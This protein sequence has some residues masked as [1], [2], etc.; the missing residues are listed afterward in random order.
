MIAYWLIPAEPARSWFTSIIKELACKYNGPIFEPH[1]T[2]YSCEDSETHTREVVSCLGER[3]AAV[4]LEPDRIGYTDGFTKTLF[5][6]FA[7]SIAADELSDAIRSESQPQQHYELQPHLSL[8]Y[9]KI[10]E[11]MKAAEAQRI[12]VPFANVQ[13]DRLAAISFSKPIESRADVEAWRIIAS[14]H[15]AR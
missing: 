13:F 15:F 9:A 4:T 7:Q 3:F 11:Q 6:E 2:V 5:L 14:A 8:L 1:L 12:R 10:D